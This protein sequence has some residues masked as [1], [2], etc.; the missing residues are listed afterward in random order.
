MKSWIV[1]AVATGLS[2]AQSDQLDKIPKC[3]FP[4]VQSYITGNQIAGC[5]P[6]DIACVCSNKQFLSSIS[7]CLAKDCS[8]D[9]IDTTIKFAA[10]LCNANGVQTPTQLVCDQDVSGT[11][12][13][14]AGSSG[15]A[16]ATQQ[17]AATNTGTGTSSSAA[18]A[19]ATTTN[20]AAPAFGK[21]GLLGAMLAVAAA[22]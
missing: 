11:A 13:K 15:A 22:L 5:K 20:A 12:S 19:T 8:K 18:A 3:A 4:C 2:T 21:G 9:D 6:A 10:S 14:T 17:T 1:L 7:C 16:T